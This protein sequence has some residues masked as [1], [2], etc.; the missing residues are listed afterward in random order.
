MLKEQA[1][2]VADILAELRGEKKY[3]MPGI[4]EET[5]RSVSTVQGGSLMGQAHINTVLDVN[6]LKPQ[7]EGL[8]KFYEIQERFRGLTQDYIPEMF[9][10]SDHTKELGMFMHSAVADGEFS[11]HDY[12]YASDLLRSIETNLPGLTE[13]LR[14]LTNT[15]E[16]LEREMGRDRNINIDLTGY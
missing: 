14:N 10:Q 15:S 3:P 9:A 13:A 7:T 1:R 16:R 2:N 8:D 4:S 6:H 12:K 5:I 11:Q